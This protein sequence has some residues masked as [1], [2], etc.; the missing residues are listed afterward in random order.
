MD[1]FF[2]VLST[3][4]VLLSCVRAQVLPQFLVDEAG[5]RRML[6]PYFQSP[7]VKLDTYDYIFNRHQVCF[8]YFVFVFI[9]WSPHAHWQRGNLDF[10][11]DSPNSPTYKPCLVASLRHVHPVRVHDSP[12]VSFACSFHDVAL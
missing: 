3:V 7:L 6:G 11:F 10:S 2:L 9:S 5:F 12:S 4:H 1:E 8:L